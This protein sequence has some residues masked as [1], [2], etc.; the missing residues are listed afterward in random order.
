MNSRAGNKLCPPVL[1]LDDHNTLPGRR[2]FKRKFVQKVLSDTNIKGYSKVI[3][4]VY[5]I[6]YK[7]TGVKE[8]I[9]LNSPALSPTGGII[10]PILL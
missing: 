1:N 6:V 5:V 10:I 8:A 9:V 3:C 4:E 2:Y 7:K